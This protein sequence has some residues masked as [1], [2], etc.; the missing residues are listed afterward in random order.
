MKKDA[1]KADWIHGEGLTYEDYASLPEGEPRYELIGGKLELMSPAPSSEHQLIS[2]NF[3]ALMNECCRGDYITLYAPI[4]LIL[5][6][7]EVR[8]PDIAMIHRGRSGLVT[9]RGIEGAPDLIVEILSPSTALNDKR[10]KRKTYARFGVKEYLI[11]DPVYRT[12]EQYLLN[13]DSQ[14]Y[15]LQNVYGQEDETITSTT[16]Q[17]LTLPI[18]DIFRDLDL[19][20][21]A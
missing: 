3:F 17:C 20:G 6:N 9:H 7:G 5:A 1:K 16:I 14:S 18:A 12:V 13:Q 21:G 11:T 19:I 8:Q 2:S 10:S 15:E 4:D